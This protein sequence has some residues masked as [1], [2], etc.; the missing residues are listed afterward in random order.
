MLL[1]LIRHSAV[2]VHKGTCYGQTDVALDEPAFAHTIGLLHSQLGNPA[3]A[4]IYSS[5]LSRCA[6]LAQELAEGQDFVLDTRLM[7]LNF[8]DWEMQAWD[9][10]D[11]NAL[12]TWMKDYVRQKP[13]GGE[14]LQDLAD[15]CAA[16]LADLR[17]K[18]SNTQAKE[19]WIIAHAGS[20]RVLLCL[21]DSVPLDRAFDQ[22]IGFGEVIERQLNQK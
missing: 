20:I 3:E 17:A 2:L 14:A 7:E 6:R 4:L 10:L 22:K 9:S 21:L 19:A 13:P 8:G 12:D 5:S 1:K 18:A 11:P 16:F 15:R